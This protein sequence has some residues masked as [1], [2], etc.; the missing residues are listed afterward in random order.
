MKPYSLNLAK[1]IIGAASTV[2]PYVQTHIGRPNGPLSTLSSAFDLNN[3]PKSAAPS[4]FERLTKGN[5]LSV[6]FDD[7]IGIDRDPTNRRPRGVFLDPVLDPMWF[8]KRKDS[9]P[10]LADVSKL[11][12][13]EP[14]TTFGDPN[15]IDDLPL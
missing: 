15:N 9:G 6:L 1:D 12:L 14:W 3:A 5:L 11:F 4:Y 8:T 10:G 2:K 7:L 13:K